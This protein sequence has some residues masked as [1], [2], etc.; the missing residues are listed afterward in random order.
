MRTER[1]TRFN[2]PLFGAKS[3]NES[4][5]ITFVKPKGLEEEIQIE[6]EFKVSFKNLTLDMDIEVTSDAQVQLIFDPQVGDVIK[7]KGDGD[8]KMT[9]DRSGDFKMFGNYYIN[10]GEYLFTLQNIINKKFLI[11]QGGTINWSGSPYN[12][13][14]DITGTYA[15]R[16]ALYELMYPDTTNDNYKRRIQVDCIL[17]MTDNLLNPNITFDVDLPNSDEATKTDV[18]NRIGVGNVQEMNRQVFGLL[19]LNRFFPT[20]DQNQALQQAGGFLETS[21][22][23]MV[24]NQLSNW[25]SKISND[26]DIGINYRP[27]DDITSDEVQASLSTQLFNNR[28]IVDGNVGVANTAAN[29]SNIVGDVNIEYKI[30]PDGRFRVRAF[31]KSND[32]NTLVE[33]APFTQGVGLSY[34]KD[35]NKLGD[36]FR[37]W[38]RKK[39]EE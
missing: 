21:S 31:N 29:S 35:F 22:A 4:D 13:L 1:G 20:E 15:V 38:K 30:T 12:A 8:I 26:F 25:L 2:I 7:G 6:D 18:R 19:V 37:K 39:D 34:Q 5:F 27:G 11:Q 10:K 9:L 23:E 36:L 32:I 33:N 16:T 3:V 28:I 14:I 17:H 24:S